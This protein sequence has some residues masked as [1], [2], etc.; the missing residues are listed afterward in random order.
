MDV[1]IIGAGHIGATAAKLFVR[2]G[3]RV[4]IGNSRGPTSLQALVEELGEGASAAEVA[5]VADGAAV[6][7][8]A[9]PLRAYPDLPAEPFTGTIVVDAMN[10]Y[11]GRDGHISEL[12][13]DLV[14]S[15][16]LLA[17]HLP[18]ARV[19]KAFNT[20]YWETLRDGG[21]PEAPREQRLAIYVAGDDHDAVG[22]VTELIEQVGFAAMITGDLASGGRRQQPGT[23]VYA[24]DL[25]AAQAA[26]VLTQG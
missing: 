5:E 19:V 2:A 22:V 20:M 8:I 17:R 1:G 21:R 9:I 24:T 6:V 12:D 13:E 25:T 16:E 3:H 14:T 18:N 23:A 7:L 4:T 10:Y 15:S 26:E 11:P